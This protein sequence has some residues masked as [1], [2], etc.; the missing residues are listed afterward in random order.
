MTRSRQ[1]VERPLRDLRVWVA[2]RNGSIQSAALTNA[3]LPANAMVGGVF[4]A[5][6]S[7]NLGLSQAVCSALCAELLS[8]A[9]QPVL[10]WLEPAAGAVYHKLGFRACGAWRSVWLRVR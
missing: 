9:K 7:R 6:A 1:G 3:E 8:E 4:T 5:P 2:E 10:Y